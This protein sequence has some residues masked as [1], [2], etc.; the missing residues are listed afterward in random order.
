MGD[1][2]TVRLDDSEVQALFSQYGKSLSDASIMTW[3]GT[4]LS[5][6]MSGAMRD[7]FDD[8]FWSSL[9]DT[10]VRMRD[11]RGLQSEDPNFETGQMYEVLPESRSITMSGGGAMFSMPDIKQLE[12]IPGTSLDGNPPDRL[13]RSNMALKYLMAQNGGWGILRG[14]VVQIPAR[15]F[16]PVINHAEVIASLG[17]YIRRYA[18]TRRG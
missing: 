17:A 15:P 13:D 7:A 4:S 9:S 16:N 8:G 18:R 2:I 5:E 1:T 11:A 3:M 6:I 12:Q 14:R 10:T